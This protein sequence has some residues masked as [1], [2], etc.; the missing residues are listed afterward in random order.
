V[1]QKRSLHA[2][3]QGVLAR[4]KYLDARF[5]G[6]PVGDALRLAGP[7]SV[8]KTSASELPGVSRPDGESSI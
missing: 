8:S 3:S 6:D 2:Q 5:P 4:G 1:I 7:E